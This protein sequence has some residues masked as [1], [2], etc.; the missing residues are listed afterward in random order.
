VKSIAR[1][2]AFA[3]PLM[4][5]AAQAQENPFPFRAPDVNSIPAGPMGD[6]VRYGRQVAMETGKYAAGYVGNGL[7]CAN[8]H[9]N[10][11]TTPKASPWV[12]IWGV[13]PEY[14]SRNASVSSLQDRINDCFVRSMN[15]RPL[16]SDSMEMQGLLAY[17]HWLSQGVPTG[18]GVEGRGLGK[19]SASLKPD[20]LHGKVLFAE[21]CASCH[22]A[23]GQGQKTAEGTY[24][25]PPL[26]GQQSF[27]IGAGMARMYTAAAFVRHNMPLGQGGTLSEQ[28]A[29][30]VA[31]YFT[32]QP[33]PDFAGKANDWPR[34]GKPKDAR[35]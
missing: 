21:K 25:F 15:G 35:Y 1:A 20:P 2:A 32:A 30:D 4:A 18:T 27:N 13:F 9:L 17:M 6:A 31:A 33:R 23:D 5:G 12:G 16:P 11:G 10:A 3:L 19:I 22:G 34:G 28:D 14:R 26:W 29:L 8:C 7:N 24:S